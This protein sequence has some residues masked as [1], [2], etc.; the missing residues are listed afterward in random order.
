MTKRLTAPDIRAMKGSQRIVALTAHDAPTAR[1]AEEGGADILLVGDS[2]AMVV[3]GHEDTLSV[4]MEEMLHHVKAVARAATRALVVADMPFGSYQESP[5]QAVRNAARFVS[6]GGARAVKIEG[7]RHMEAV[8]AII[9]AGVPVMGHVGL[10]PQRL[11]E[12]GS[13]TVQGK[14]VPAAA[15]I[16]SEAN[17]LAKA[18]CFSVVLECLPSPL[19]ARVTRAVSAPTIGIGAG[20][21]CDGQ[22]L[23]SYDVL[24]LQER[25]APRF[26]KRYAS[27][28]REAAAALAAYSGEVRAGTFPA[29]EHGYGLPGGLSEDDLDR[30]LEETLARDED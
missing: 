5:R 29:P 30:L 22:V 24:G 4:T 19:A 23:V 2:L 8:R 10:T 15:A 9:D 16:L 20:P 11:A 3:L 21:D 14:S 28:A 26:V 13:F 12:I 7:A 1:L 25:L 17:V 18:G 27:L 6:E